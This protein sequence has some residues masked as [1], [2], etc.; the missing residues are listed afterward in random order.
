MRNTLNRV[1][2]RPSQMPWFETQPKKQRRRGGG[3]D[4]NDGN[5]GDGGDIV[6]NGGGDGDIEIDAQ[7]ITPVDTPYD[8]YRK[9]E[10]GS[11][12]Q[13]VDF[14]M[15]GKTFNAR[16]NNRLIGDHFRKHNRD[17]WS[18]GYT[19]KSYVKSFVSP[20]QH[21]LDAVAE[22]RKALED[23]IESPMRNRRK[24]RRRL[25]DGSELCPDAWLNRR[26]D[27]WSEMYK[28]RVPKHVIE[29]GINMTIAVNEPK[30]HLLWRGA[31]TAVLVDALTALGHS[32]GVTSYIATAHI[33]DTKAPSAYLWK[34]PVKR[35]DMPLDL[36]T[37]TM[38]CACAG[39]LRF[40]GFAVMA[41]TVH[42]RCS[43]KFGFPTSLPAEEAG[44]FDFVMPRDAYTLE[45]SVEIV[46]QQIQ[47]F[48]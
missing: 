22:A 41:R 25:E 19:Q 38:C 46:R 26:I 12:M 45:R 5:G 35:P 8:L 6:I 28:R 47:Q 20:P 29:I 43:R 21:L 30:S 17:P 10:M 23:V 37:V 15:G 18:G 40:A 1:D 32:V 33:D 7:S 48:K 2:L 3:D 24:L 44:D 13:F 27:G 39:F 42:G 9:I 11:A 36:N 4:G 31:C 14:A 34:V 16:E